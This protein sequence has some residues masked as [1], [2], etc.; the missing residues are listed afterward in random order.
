MKCLCWDHGIDMS[1]LHRVQ[2]DVQSVYLAPAAK[3][4]HGDPLLESRMR[5]GLGLFAITIIRNTFEACIT[6]PAKRRAVM[7]AR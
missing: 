2:N 3:P 1:L 7:P 6:Q 4:F 5:G